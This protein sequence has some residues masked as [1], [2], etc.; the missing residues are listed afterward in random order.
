[1]PQPRG[2]RGD[3]AAGRGEVERRVD[4]GREGGG[5]ER[6]KEPVAGQIR[7]RGVGQVSELRAERRLHGVVAQE[8]REQGADRG[9]VR[10]L[11]RVVVGD[12]VG[13]QAVQQRRRQ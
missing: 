11:E 1:T 13:G 3:G 12:A 6:G 4:A 10:D 2:H 9:Q 5:D 7:R 8:R